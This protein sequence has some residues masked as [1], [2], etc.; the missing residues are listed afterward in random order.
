[1]TEERSNPGV[2][3][4]STSSEELKEGTNISMDSFAAKKGNTINGG[5]T[6]RPVRL[7]RAQAKWDNTL[8]LSLII[9]RSTQDLSFKSYNAFMDYVLCGIPPSRETI[10]EAEYQLITGEQ[11]G[12]KSSTYKEL[13]DN[14]RRLPFTDTDA[15][16]L[17]KVATEAFVS[18]NCAVAIDKF[19]F[20]DRVDLDLLLSEISADTPPGTLDALWSQYL[21]IARVAQAAELTVF[22]GALA[23]ACLGFLWFNCHPAQLFMGDVG[24]LG[25]G[26]T[27]GMLALLIKQ[28]FLLLM[29]AGVF[30]LEALSVLL[31]VSY[32]K[33]TGGRR[34]FRMAPL[35]HHFELSGWPEEKVVVRFWILGIVFALFSLATLKLR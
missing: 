8:L 16:R 7:S 3:Q 35:H 20:K 19:T 2:E 15:Y 18:V 10:G 26:A 31:Q 34:L 17:L 28:E 29:L 32:F 9:E 25:L 5:N 30:I 23:G 6:N 14:K 22:A 33:L 24:A 27:L 4:S 1:M 11:P 13:R 21:S 12:S